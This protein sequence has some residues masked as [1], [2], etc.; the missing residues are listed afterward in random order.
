MRNHWKTLFLVPVLTAGAAAQTTNEDGE[1]IFVLSPFEVTAQEGWVATNSIAATKFEADLREIPLT[2]NVV[3]SD[4]IRDIGATTLSDAMRYTTGIITQPINASGTSGLGQGFNTEYVMRGQNVRFVYRDG[5][6]RWRGDEPFFMDRVEVIK[7]PTAMLYGQAQPGGTLNYIAKR[8]LFDPQGEIGFRV[9]NHGGYRVQL[10]ATGPIGE[11]KRVAFRFATAYEGGKTWID[12]EEVEYRPFYGIVTFRP[13]DGTL[14]TVSSEYLD[15]RVDNL[16]SNGTVAWRGPENRG[17]SNL[18][19][20]GPADPEGSGGQPIGIHPLADPSNNPY[21]SPG[22]GNFFNNTSSTHSVILDQNITDGLDFRTAFFRTEVNARGLFNGNNDVNALQLTVR[23]ENGNPYTGAPGET[24]TNPY[25]G[26]TFV[27]GSSHNMNANTVEDATPGV[28]RGG[29]RQIALAAPPGGGNLTFVGN[30]LASE[31]FFNPNVVGP[32]PLSPFGTVNTDSVWQNDLV[33]RIETDTAEHRILLGF[34]YIRSTFDQQRTSPNPDWTSRGGNSLSGSDPNFFGVAYDVERRMTVDIFGNEWTGPGPTNNNVTSG[35]NRQYSGTNSW[36]GSYTG[37]FFER[38]LHV[39]AGGRETRVFRQPVGA[40]EREYQSK[41]VPQFGA[42]YQ[43]IDE[44]SVYASYSESFLNT[45]ARFTSQEPAVPG[46]YTPGAPFPPE[47]GTGIDVGLK[48]ELAGGAL[49]GNLTYFDIERDQIEIVDPDVLNVQGNPVRFPSGE[50]RSKGF[51]LELF[52][53]PSRALTLTA[54]IT[55][56]D[57]KFTR[58]SR[59]QE[60][61]VGE[62]RFGSTKWQ[63]SLFAKYTFLDGGMEGLTVGGGAY[64]VGPREID[65]GRPFRNGSYTVFDALVSYRHEVAGFHLVH[66]LNINNVFDREYYQG[67][68]NGF[69]PRTFLLS[70]RMEF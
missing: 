62:Q 14:L 68:T 61:L 51:E 18:S 54:G 31:D 63:G 48:F 4:F 16:Q 3:T 13:W 46:T 10:D 52:Y 22:L 25:S 38:R 45:N 21:G 47:S 23:D 2:I 66:S 55:H 35:R 24:W 29:V 17:G 65:P 67:F 28:F 19:A 30:S 9:T 7:G 5:V 70:S 11:S 49:S 59:D 20:A 34:E 8:P 6:R 42:L 69:A 53:A 44:V 36:Y 12:W 50:E 1:E 60:Y 27:I 57:S 37:A 33:Y 26:Q 40:D 15:R 64:Y 58:V 39:L 56:A 41:F 32:R 43:V